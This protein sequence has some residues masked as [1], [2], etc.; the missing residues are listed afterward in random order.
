MF[1][2]RT[3]EKSDFKGAIRIKKEDKLKL[4]LGKFTDA[5]GKIWDIAGIFFLESG[6]WVQATPY[7]NL[8][9]YY[10]DTSTSHWGFVF[11]RWEPYKVEFV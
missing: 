4:R 10:S 8:H 11:Q 2:L 7:C 9:P 1:Q 6:D 5:D 3:N